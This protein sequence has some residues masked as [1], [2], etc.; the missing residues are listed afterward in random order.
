MRFANST[1][2]SQAE[3]D[4]DVAESTLGNHELQPFYGKALE[5]HNVP[6]NANLACNNKREWNKP[7]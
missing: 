4:V 1:D 7:C 5:H 6:V 3:T 2:I